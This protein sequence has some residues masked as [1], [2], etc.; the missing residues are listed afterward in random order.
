MTF[1][2]QIVPNPTDGYDVRRA[3]D[4]FLAQQRQAGAGAGREIWPFL[5]LPDQVTTPN[6]SA[7][8]N[9]KTANTGATLISDFEG[10]VDGQVIFIK[11]G[12]ANTDFD[13]TSSGLQ[14]NAGANWTTAVAGDSMTCVYD[15]T[16]WLCDISDNTA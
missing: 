1:V 6:V 11:I 10:G 16:G 9:F 13:F 12:D 2:P 8:R 14:G 5:T 7:G 15:G 4:E 3:Q